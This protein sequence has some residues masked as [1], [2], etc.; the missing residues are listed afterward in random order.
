MD[1]E[2][3]ELLRSILQTQQEHLNLY[4]ENAA[5]AANYQETALQAQQTAMRRQK[6]QVRYALFAIAMLTVGELL[7][8][9][10]LF[11]PKQ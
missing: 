3:K 6:A 8:L 10:I 1:D 7:I 5:K 11:S 4:R 2:I 9:W